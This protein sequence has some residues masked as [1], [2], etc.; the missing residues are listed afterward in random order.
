MSILVTGAT[1]NVGRHLVRRLAEDGR[2]VRAMTRRPDTTDLPAGVEAVGGDLTDPASMERAL[3]GATAMYLLA[4]HGPSYETLPNP[5]DLVAAAAKAGV[6]RVTVMWNGFRGPVEAAVEASGLEWTI[7]EPGEFMSNALS[8]AEEIRA[9]GVVR[10]PFADIGHA[11]V[12]ET[13]LAA[14]AAETLTADGHAGR[15]YTLTGPEVIT[16]GEQVAALSR[17][18]GRPIRYEEQTVAEARDRMRRMG[19][20]DDSIDFI[21][22]WRADP[23]ESARTVSGV[24]EAVT[25]RPGTT[26]D[27]WARRNAE[28]FQ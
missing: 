19:V 28:H 20:G 15:S 10:E 12:A 8:W 1:G 2:P 24:V 16:V 25:G 3:E 4:A 21:L 14:V 13:D 18:T 11:P 17:A 9:E 5:A 22:G 26:F 27:Q 23:P 6:R 7:L